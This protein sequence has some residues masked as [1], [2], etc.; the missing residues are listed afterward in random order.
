MV[1]ALVLVLGGL[2]IQGLIYQM[3]TMW[4]EGIAI[5]AFWVFLFYAAMVVVRMMGLTY[6][7]HALDLHWFRR[8]PRWASSAAREQIYAN[9]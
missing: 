4:V 8:R 3:P 5:W 9:S 1:G 6:H 2:A 7:A